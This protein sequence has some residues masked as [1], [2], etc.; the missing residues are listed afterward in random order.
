M[1][2]PV[3]DWSLYL[4]TDPILIGERDVVDVVMRAVAGGVTVVQFRDKQADDPDFADTGRRLRDALSQ[5]SVPLIINDRVHLVADIG[6]NG[7]HIGQTDM[8]LA[9]TRSILGMHA[10]IG[11][12]VESPAQAAPVNIRDVDYLGVSP[13]YSTPTK[14]DTGQPWGLK[15]LRRLREQTEMVPLIAIGGINAHNAADVIRAGADGL[16]V[17]SAICAAP[18]PERAARDIREIIEGARDY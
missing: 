7:A 1:N 10:L 11:L 8:S 14:T 3:I 2:R 6:A 5:T 17:V 9:Q 12:S 18:D 16:A 4:V 13:I 15:G